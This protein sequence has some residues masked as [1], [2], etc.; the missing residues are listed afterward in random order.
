MFA[1]TTTSTVTVHSGKCAVFR[2][3]EPAV[4]AVIIKRR[5]DTT[6]TNYCAGHDRQT[7]TP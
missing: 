3:G 7:I 5:R 1:C 2:C 4:K 6:T